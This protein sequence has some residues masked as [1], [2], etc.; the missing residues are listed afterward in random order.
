MSQLPDDSPPPL[1]VLSLPPEPV[2][3]VYPAAP[4]RSGRPGVIN[5]IAITSIVIASLSIITGIGAGLMDF[6]FIMMS[7]VASSMPVPPAPVA[8]SSAMVV[9]GG[10]PERLP[11]DGLAAADRQT[12]ADGLQRVRTLTADQLE[13]LDEM[14][15]EHGKTI[16]GSANA[17]SPDQLAATIANSGHMS[18]G[19]STGSD[20]FVLSTGK[21]EISADRAVFFPTGGQ[22]SIRSNAVQLPA[23]QFGYAPTSLQPDQ[24]RS[25]LRT[26][27]DLNGAKIKST[28]SKTLITTLQSPGRQII[29][30]TTDGTDPANEIT[31]AVTLPDGML[32]LTT[33]HGSTTSSLSCDASGSVVSQSSYSGSTGAMVTPPTINKTAGIAAVSATLAQFLLAIYLLVIGIMTLRFSPRGRL[34]HWI[35]VIL[36]LPL[37]IATAAATAWMWSTFMQS[38]VAVSATAGGPAAAPPPGAAASAA[39]A[40]AMFGIVPGVLGCI[41]P[42]VLIFVLLSKSVR[43]YYAAG[44]G[45]TSAGR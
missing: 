41:W 29:V 23:P 6:S 16:A 8:A 9:T 27:N 26:I 33:T 13:Q 30:P 14:L 1:P 12:Y 24:I 28:Q 2:Y 20:Y 35:Y 40:G 37:A 39:S 43:M 38:A 3:P 5:F 44:T 4:L 19:D 25:I 17:P 36:K 15:A 18:F 21:L 42:I 11:F 34:L 45:I 7:A 32:E 22:P 31:S 10:A